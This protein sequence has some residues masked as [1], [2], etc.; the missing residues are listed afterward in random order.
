MKE[1]TISAEIATLDKV[2]A[3]VAQLHQDGRRATA[4]AVFAIIGGGSKP[5]ILKHLKTLREEPKPV[6]GDV[7]TAIL[8]LARPALAQ[9]FAEGG[10]TEAARNRDQTERLHRMLGD[11]EAEV[12]ALAATN[13]MQ[14][15]K[16]ADLEAELVR[17]ANALSVSEENIGLKDRKIEQLQAELVERDDTAR[18]HLDDTLGGFDDKLASLARQMEQAGGNKGR[19]ADRG[20]DAG[21]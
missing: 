18:K 10:K 4:D 3:A 9:V 14:E 1:T 16:I 15:S 20:Q 7:P 12:E 19:S 8:D 21:T 17:T 6:D 2:E 13:V 11:L 5:T